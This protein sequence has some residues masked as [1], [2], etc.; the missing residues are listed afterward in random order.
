MCI[1]EQPLGQHRLIMAGSILIELLLGLVP[2]HL[3]AENLE[4]KLS[5]TEF[6][7]NRPGRRYLLENSPANRLGLL[8]FALKLKLSCLFL[9]L[10]KG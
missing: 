1:H 8:L 2:G 4:E 7:E 9:P 5:K 6:V 3:V 10:F